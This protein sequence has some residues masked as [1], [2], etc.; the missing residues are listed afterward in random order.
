MTSLNIDLV[1]FSHLRWDF[2]FQRP[3][4]LMSRFA[5]NSRVYFF[6]E[7]IFEG[8][9][10]R[11]NSIR[12]PQTGVQVVTPFLPPHTSREATSE[13]LKRLLYSL[14]QK[15]KIEKFVARYYTP[16]ALEF[17]NDLPPAVTVYGCMH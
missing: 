11:I 12:C 10:P 7:P 9:R 1:C 13:L 2:V 3:Q 16:M 17:S 15:E 8:D 6:E 14:F 4:H 5:R